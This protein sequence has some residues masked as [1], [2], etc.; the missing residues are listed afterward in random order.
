M[1]LGL[2]ARGWRL[3]LE[4]VPLARPSLSAMRKRVASAAGESRARLIN[5]SM[6]CSSLVGVTTAKRVRDSSDSRLL[7]TELADRRVW[8]VELVEKE[9]AVRAGPKAR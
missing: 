6:N 5:S 3:S 1:R 9:T 7:E 8:V 2:K 4:R